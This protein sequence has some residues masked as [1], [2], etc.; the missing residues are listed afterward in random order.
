MELN[1]RFNYKMFI[2]EEMMNQA[3]MDR[4]VSE[5]ILM[6]ENKNTLSNISILN[7]GFAEK[8]KSGIVK[9]AQ[10]IGT[11]WKKFLEAMNTLIKNDKGYLEKYKDTILK[12][13]MVDATYTMYNYP[14]ALSGI[15]KSAT[16]PQFNYQSMKDSLETDEKFIAAHFSQYEVQG[17]N[18]TFEDQMKAK[19]RG[20]TKEIP[21]KSSQIKMVDLYNYC[22]NYE[23]I[24]KNIQK[25]RDSIK[26]AAM[27]GVELI[28]KMVRNDEVTKEHTYYLRDKEYYYSNIYEQ[29]VL[30][31]ERTVNDPDNQNSGTSNRDTSGGVANNPSSG[32]TFA[33]NNKNVQDQKDDPKNDENIRQDVKT[34]KEAEEASKRIQRYMKIC[35]QFLAA[36]ATVFEEIYKTYMEII[37]THVRDHLGKEK[38]KST[39][40]SAD[41]GTD[42]SKD[43][44]KKEQNT[45]NTNDMD[46][47]FTGEL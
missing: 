7:E 33:K 27:A 24:M 14:L 21:L 28:D 25:D 2:I 9:I 39:N 29:Y 18:D 41:A 6:C 17:S 45:G 23:G 10:A 37:K 22:Y 4:Y 16:V 20:S 8:I 3:E 31:M 40:Q 34:N 36:K 43:G 13:K 11:I 46:K 42:Y 32:D 19:F 12:K 26:T 30:E 15:L 1:D 35:G 47:Y 38:D 44:N 5:C